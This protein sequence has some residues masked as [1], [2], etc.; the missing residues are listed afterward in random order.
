MTFQPRKISET[1]LW[2]STMRASPSWRGS[3]TLCCDNYDNDE[4]VEIDVGRWRPLHDRIIEWQRAHRALIDPSWA[5]R[6]FD[7]STTGDPR[8]PIGLIF[9]GF[10][11]ELAG[12]WQPTYTMSLR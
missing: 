2:A 1:G 12:R 5:E 8:E 7:S 11:D 10:R 6:V 9:T 3:G 4:T